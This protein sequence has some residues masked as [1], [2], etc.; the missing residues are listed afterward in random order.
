MIPNIA[1]IFTLYVEHSGKIIV[2]LK[3]G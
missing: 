1:L 3:I 2:D